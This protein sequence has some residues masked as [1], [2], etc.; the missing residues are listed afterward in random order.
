[1]P[2]V[3]HFYPLQWFTPIAR[4]NK[5][6]RVK[7]SGYYHTRSELDHR[8]L[9][10]LGSSRFDSV[11]VTSNQT[12]VDG[13]GSRVE[14]TIDN[15]P[16]TIDLGVCVYWREV[17]SNTNQC[18]CSDQWDNFLDNY[19]NC[20]VTIEKKYGFV[21]ADW[22]TKYSRASGG[23]RRYKNHRPGYSSAFG[24][25]KQHWWEGIGGDKDEGRWSMVD[26]PWMTIL[27]LTGQPTPNDVRR[28]F[29]SLALKC[30][31]DRGGTQDQMV[32]L[33]LAYDAAKKELCF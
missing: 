31:P 14:S 22:R 20:V 5:A 9:Q 8:L 24:E 11:Y 4:K 2:N 30:H 13:R 15:R 28:A 29:R 21:N 12:M 26:A 6:Q 18:I 3:Q 17:S 32:K 1:M 25:K 16:S 7:W 27:G 19:W 10:A 23:G 33:N